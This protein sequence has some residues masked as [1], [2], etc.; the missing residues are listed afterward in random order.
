M[1]R[2]EKPAAETPV[3]DVATEV[4][5]TTLLAELIRQ[6]R[7]QSQV[8]QTHLKR[9]A[10]RS[11]QAGPHISAFNPRGEKDYPM[12]PLKC[13]VN[14]P[15]PQRPGL[16]GFTR[17]EVELMNL[18]EPGDYVI[19]LNDG[20]P[21]RVSVIGKKNHADGRL[22]G[23]TFSGP[24]DPDSGRYTPL[25]TAENKQ[26]FPTCANLLRQI[27]G[28]KADGVLPMKQEVALIADGTLA[29]SLGE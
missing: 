9:S 25:F 26:R 14:M 16:H 11:N 21:Q 8:S 6:G 13:E 22:E 17:E 7:E 18:V 27:V 24:L 28:A 1:P 5:L 4:S 2:T 15:F 10:P 20:N 29:V 23:L 19:E 12:P 3:V